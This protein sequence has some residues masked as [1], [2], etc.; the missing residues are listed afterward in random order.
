LAGLALIQPQQHHLTFLQ[1][2][3]S[4]CLQSASR[5]HTI[6]EEK[7]SLT[8][9]VQHKR[10]APFDTDSRAAENL[11]HFGQRA[12]LVPQLDAQILHCAAPQFPA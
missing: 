6:L 5:G 7:V 9:A 4:G 3:N 11:S 1:N 12:W 10:A 2:P 8:P